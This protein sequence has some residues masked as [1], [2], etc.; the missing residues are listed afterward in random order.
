MY[1]RVL[2]V[3]LNENDK[4]TKNNGSTESMVTPEMNCTNLVYYGQQYPNSIEARLCQRE[5]FDDKYEIITLSSF[6][7]KMDPQIRASG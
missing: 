4:L 1:K 3:F 5:Y 2:I 6:T 7:R